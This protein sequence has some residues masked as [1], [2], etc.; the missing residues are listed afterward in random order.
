MHFRIFR[1]K[2]AYLIIN[3]LY[4]INIKIKTKKLII[5][6]L[7]AFQGHKTS[8]AKTPE[9]IILIIFKK[10]LCEFFCKFNFRRRIRFPR[11]LNAYRS[12]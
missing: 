12:R 4:L 3:N 1:L 8:I 6:Y 7:N 10:V 9:N 5:L 11:P 2:Q